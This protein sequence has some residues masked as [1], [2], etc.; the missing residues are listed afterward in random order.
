MV[1]IELERLILERAFYVP[2]ANSLPEYLEVADGR[3]RR[4]DICSKQEVLAAAR[5]HRVI[6]R[7]HAGE[8]AR[9]REFATLKF[10][11]EDDG[12]GTK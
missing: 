3:F 12:K 9:L 8:A 1:D 5:L 6:S 7:A 2:Q 11:K 10:R 4:L